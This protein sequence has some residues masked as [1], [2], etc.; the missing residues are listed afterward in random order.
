MVCFGQTLSVVILKTSAR[1]EMT[2]IIWF[3]LVI[4]PVVSLRRWLDGL[5]WS[6]SLGG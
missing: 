1:I 5:C 6:D 4:L 3:V 2:A